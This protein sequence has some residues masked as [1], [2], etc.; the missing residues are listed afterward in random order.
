[1]E[2]QASSLDHKPRKHLTRDQRLEI[3]TLLKFGFSIKRICNEL[4]VTRRQVKYTFQQKEVSPGI[5]TGR[6]PRLSL[7]QADELEAFI[8][9]S[10]IARRMT[11]LE[12]ASK[13]FSHWNCGEKAIRTALASKG[14]RRCQVR[15]RPEKGKAKSEKEV[16]K[17]G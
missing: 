6:P 13:Q 2:P 16:S 5:R 12:L 4:G 1:M 14:Y 8:S 11:Y 17:I 7:E 10:T 9:S 3:K 15:T